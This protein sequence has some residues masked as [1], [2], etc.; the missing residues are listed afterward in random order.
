MNA[1]VLCAGVGRRMWPLT[2]RMP[3][4]AIP[5]LGRPMII[6]VLQRLTQFGVTRA[7]INLHHLPDHMR[8]LLGRGGLNGLPEIRFS[9]EETILG[10]GG[11]LRNAAPLLGGDGPILVTN[12]D[13]L[14]DIDIA[15]VLEA[16]AQ[17]DHLA[18][19]VLIP[20]RAG[21]SIVDVGPD[22][23]ILSI[24]GEPQA[25]PERIAEKCLFTGMHVIDRELLERIPTRGSSNIITVYRELAAA[26][27][28]AAYMHDGFWWE[29]GSP[30]LY[31]AG[32]LRMFDLELE[33]RLHVAD[34]DKIEKLGG[35][36]VACGAGIEIDAGTRLSGRVALGFSSRVGEG[37]LI[38]DSVVMPETWI[39]PNCRIR[40]SVIAQGLEIPAG[41]EAE[42]ELV[43]ADIGIGYE[44]PPATR[45]SA[46][47]LI[48]PLESAR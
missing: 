36:R 9:F 20:A 44:L 45:R 13:F 40:G 24:A 28:I 12:C 3:K 43:C 14:A 35:A 48:H 34:H 10:T 6:Q 32:S 46:G 2:L 11:G 41:F 21:Y 25:N 22:G 31:L 15:A 5:V 1:M 38:E 18:T 37:C 16:H 47:H 23:G 17:S 29:F 42:N 33:Q 8:A 4:P 19:L 7:A 39:G 30:S 26:G 27:R